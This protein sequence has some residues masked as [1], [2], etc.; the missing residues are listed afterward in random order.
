MDSL[1]HRILGIAPVWVYLVVTLLVFAEDAIFI[2]F[3]IPG[4]TAA[5]IGGVA[6]SQ[7]HVQLWAMIVLVVAAAIV[8]DSVGFEVGKHFGTRLLRASVL[9]SHRGRLDRA[10]DF[11]A[12]RGGWA[13]FLGRFTAF[14][15]AVMPALAGTSKMPYRRFLTFNAVGGVVWGITFVVL[16]FVAGQ[17]YEAVAKTVGRSMAIAVAVIVVVALIVWRLRERRRDKAVEAEYEAAADAD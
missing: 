3:V 5:V 16:G 14:F 4:E 15:R 10:Q 2:G 11:L 1:L 12:R 9:D 17:S 13:V 6:A 7:G 8:G